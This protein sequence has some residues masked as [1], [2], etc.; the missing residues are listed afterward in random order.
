[1]KYLINWIKLRKVNIC[2]DVDV[3][4]ELSTALSEYGLSN[5]YEVLKKHSISADNILVIGEDTLREWNV[6]ENDILTYKRKTL[7]Y[8]ENKRN[9]ERVQYSKLAAFL[10]SFF[11]GVLGADWFYLSAGSAAYIVAGIFKLITAGGFGVWWLV[12][13]IR[14]LADTF[15]DGNGISLRNDM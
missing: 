9:N 13:W 14:V 12:D 1:M 6:S 10:V 4:D 3:N 2:I 11:V 8:Q 7:E 15:P 5:L